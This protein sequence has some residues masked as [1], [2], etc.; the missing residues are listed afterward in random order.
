MAEVKDACGTPNA[1]FKTPISAIPKKSGGRR[2]SNRFAA[3]GARR[4]GMRGEGQRQ[5]P[6]GGLLLTG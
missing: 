2:A 3:P 5:R 4:G 6:V 1:T